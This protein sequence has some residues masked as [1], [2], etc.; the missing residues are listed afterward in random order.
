[1]ILGWT[2]Y[3]GNDNLVVIHSSID[4]LRFRCGSILRPRKE[5]YYAMLNGVYLDAKAKFHTGV[6]PFETMDE[7]KAAC[8]RY[9]DLMVLR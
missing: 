4:N 5:G 2:A 7:A 3:I 8:Q 6:Q 9:Y 1:M